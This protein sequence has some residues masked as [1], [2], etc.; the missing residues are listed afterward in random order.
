MYGPY[1]YCIMVACWNVTPG[2]ASSNPTS[3]HM[4][5]CLLLFYIIAHLNRAAAIDLVMSHEKEQQVLQ[6][7]HDLLSLNASSCGTSIAF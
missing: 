5:E 2:N 3:C 6:K 7:S 4:L 1:V